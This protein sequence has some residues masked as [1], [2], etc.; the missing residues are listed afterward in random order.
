MEEI[1]ERPVILSGVRIEIESLLDEYDEVCD[2]DLFISELTKLIKRY[3]T[4]AIYL[5][6]GKR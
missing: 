3:C 5:E 1:E 4:A 2:R 6:R